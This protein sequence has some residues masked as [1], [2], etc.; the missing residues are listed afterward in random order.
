MPQG[1]SSINTLPASPARLGSLSRVRPPVTVSKAAATAATSPRAAPA[2]RK[3]PP[4]LLGDWFNQ[5]NF[6][7]VL[8][9]PAPFRETRLRRPPGLAKT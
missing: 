4:K 7:N 8:A 1:K 9:V 3:P 6:F 5:T 2:H